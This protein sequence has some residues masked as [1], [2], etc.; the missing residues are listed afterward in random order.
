MTISNK[1]RIELIN[2]Y[3]KEL[4]IFLSS[5]KIPCSIVIS[6]LINTLIDT[7]S[8]LNQECPGIGSELFYNIEMSFKK[9]REGI[10]ES[11]N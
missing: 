11:S 8:Y 6:M 3:Q 10:N 2:L 7:V 9:C 4:S 1:S 5:H